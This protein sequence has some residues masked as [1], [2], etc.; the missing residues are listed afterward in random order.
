MADTPTVLLGD[1]GPEL[2]SPAQITTGP[3]QIT[4]LLHTGGPTVVID[5]ANHEP[6]P[7]LPR[8][9]CPIRIDDAGLGSVFRGNSD[10]YRHHDSCSYC[11]SMS[12]DTFM[13][14]LREGT[15]TLTP[16][17]KNY[18]VYVNREGGT[19]GKFYFRHLSAEQQEEFVTLHNEGTLQLSYPGHFYVP[20][21][22]TAVGLPTTPLL[23]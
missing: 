11:G 16:T 7:D 4:T 13:A 12:G 20:P 8:H 6:Q 14:A 9:T 15:A 18:K 10:T 19:T 2:Q 21:F 22:F 17:D 5:L 3:A 23:R 1:P